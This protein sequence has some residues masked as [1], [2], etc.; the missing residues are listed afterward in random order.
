MSTRKSMLVRTSFAATIAAGL[1]FGAVHAYAVPGAPAHE[2]RV[3]EFDDCTRTCG[4]QGLNGSCLGASC[5]C[6]PY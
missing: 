1:G 2:R 3:C 6:Y 4:T 5:V